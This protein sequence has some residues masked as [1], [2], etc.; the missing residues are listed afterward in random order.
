MNEMSYLVL[1][2]IL[3]GS[4]FIGNGLTSLVENKN[5]KEALPF[6]LTVFLMRACSLL[7]GFILTVI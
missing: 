4:I 2:L 5:F 1:G 6:Y 7:I 3:F